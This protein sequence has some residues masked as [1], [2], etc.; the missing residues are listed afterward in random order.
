MSRITLTV[1]L[2]LVSGLGND[3][4]AADGLKDPSR[5]ESKLKSYLETVGINNPK[6][7]AFTSGVASRMEGK[8]L[9][10]AE[11]KFESGRIVLHYRMEPKIS[12][13]QFELKFQPTDS[14]RSEIVA[15]TKSVMY[16]YKW[17]F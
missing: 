13:R 5:K 7:L 16:Q 10:L 4:A 17:E 3:A 14:K 11:E 8:N 9:R 15:T 1:A 12:T 2:L 6:I